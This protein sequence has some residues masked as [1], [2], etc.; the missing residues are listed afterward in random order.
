MLP[1]HHTQLAERA[2]CKFPRQN[3]RA[4]VRAPYRSNVA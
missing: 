4:R 1:G 3:N 2:Y